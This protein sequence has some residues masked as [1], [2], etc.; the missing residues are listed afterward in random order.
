MMYVLMNYFS[1]HNKV[2]QSLEA[3][4]A[5]RGAGT[6]EVSGFFGEI[7]NATYSVSVSRVLGENDFLVLLKTRM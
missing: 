5:L 1:V 6:D 2:I 7:G 4:S 3:R